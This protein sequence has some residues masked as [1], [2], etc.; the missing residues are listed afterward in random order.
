MQ[1]EVVWLVSFWRVA[2]TEIWEVLLKLIENVGQ[3]ISVLIDLLSFCFALD[4][5]FLGSISDLARYTLK[6]FRQ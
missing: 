6:A 2:V 4:C 3:V 1:E 5:D